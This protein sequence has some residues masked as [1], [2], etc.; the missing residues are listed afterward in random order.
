MQVSEQLEGMF[1]PNVLLSR[2]RFRYTD[3][4]LLFILMNFLLLLWTH[5]WTFTLF[6]TVLPILL[7]CCQFCPRALPNL[8]TS[9]PI[10]NHST[11][12]P[13][14][15][16]CLLLLL[17][18]PAILTPSFPQ[19][20]V[21]INPLQSDS[22]WRTFE[23]C[24]THDGSGT[25]WPPWGLVAT[26]PNWS[27]DGHIY[28]GEEGQSVG[29]K[30]RLYYYPLRVLCTAAAVAAPSRDTTFIL[31]YLLKICNSFF[32]LYFVVNTVFWLPVWCMSKNE[33]SSRIKKENVRVIRTCCTR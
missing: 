8:F 17:S 15:H 19:R 9:I 27:S 7:T 28:Q 20:R 6:S 29:R 18:S 1:L 33:N 11:F 14:L 26:F 10:P 24:K 31:Q 4:S 2:R 25:K 22:F 13:I 16:L 23:R 12:F 32:E 3:L 30:G 5:R 21:L